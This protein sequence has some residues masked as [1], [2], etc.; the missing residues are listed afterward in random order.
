MKYIKMLGLAAMAAMALM[1]FVGA[2][3]ASAT[4][5]EDSKGVHPT[6]IS[7][8]LLGS[9]TLESTTG[10][11]PTVFETC[12]TGTVHGN[13]STGSATTTVTGVATIASGGCTATTHVLGGGDLEIHHITG[14]SNGTVTGNTFEVT[15]SMFG[16]SC[17]YGLSKTDAMVHLGTLI[18]SYTTPLMEVNTILPLRAGSFLCPSETRWTATYEVTTPSGLTVT[19][20]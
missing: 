12:T 7:A 4:T 17:V 16:A 6:T 2:G 18:G 20:G 8:S 19:A 11:P 9:A 10:S 14:T 13:P 1:A 3:T 15:K 5:L